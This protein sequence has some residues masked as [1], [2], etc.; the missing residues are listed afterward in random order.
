M[1]IF[2]KSFLKKNSRVTRLLKAGDFEVLNL[3]GMDLEISMCECV[4]FLVAHRAAYRIGNAYVD[5]I[6]TKITK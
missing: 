5:E 1:Y 2:A 4:W 3:C 6:I